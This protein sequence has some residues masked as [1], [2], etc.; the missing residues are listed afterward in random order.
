MWLLITIGTIVMVL[1]TLNTWVER[2][3]L[4]TDSW[5]NASTALLDDDDVRH[6]LSVRLVNA[7]YE[8]V[9]VGTD[10]RQ[11]AS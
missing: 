8:N 3:L 9:D 4:D 6:E 5:V 2:Q 1:S 7:L 11:P 10:H